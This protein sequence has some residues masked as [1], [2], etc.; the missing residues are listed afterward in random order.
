MRTYQLR[1]DITRCIYMEPASHVK[2][3]MQ[4]LGQ[5]VA[6]TSDRWTRG[7]RGSR[8]SRAHMLYLRGSSQTYWIKKAKVMIHRLSSTNY[9][10]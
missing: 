4:C 2:T 9:V 5:R 1:Y 6:L 8:G 3:V 7:S 10:S